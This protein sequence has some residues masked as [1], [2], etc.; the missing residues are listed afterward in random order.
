M[1]DM[2]VA[3]SEVHYLAPSVK[4]RIAERMSRKLEG[5]LTAAKACGVSNH[6]AMMEL[7]ADPQYRAQ[8]DRARVIIAEKLEEEY[9]SIADE[10]VE[11]RDMVARQSLRLKARWNVISRML[12]RLRE[13][14]TSLKQVNNY[15]SATITMSPEQQQEHARAAA[16][17][18]EQARRLAADQ[19]LQV[20]DATCS[21]EHVHP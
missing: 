3:K 18:L 19:Q 11:G 15:S 16:A 6:R 21:D 9:I 14:P 13:N 2:I 10:Q 4:E 17:A 8:V 7:E 5:Y 12:P 20:I 1:T